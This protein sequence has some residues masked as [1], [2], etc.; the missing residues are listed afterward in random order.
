MNGS[1]AIFDFEKILENEKAAH[2]S[3]KEKEIIEWKEKREEREREKEQMCKDGGRR[4]KASQGMG[5]KKRPGIVLKAAERKSEIK[6]MKRKEGREREVKKKGKRNN[7]RTRRRK[8]KITRKK[9]E[10]HHQKEEN[11]EERGSQERTTEDHHKKMII[12]SLRKIIIGSFI[13]KD[14]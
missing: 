1:T 5:R 14:H 10:D 13:H 12:R 11:K 4:D 9:E 8:K 6:G 2:N 3:K 7:N